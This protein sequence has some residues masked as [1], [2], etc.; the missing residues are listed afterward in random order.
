MRKFFILICLATF[1]SSTLNAQTNGA[2]PASNGSTTNKE[3]LK[4]EAPK[5]G[6]EIPPEK[7]VPINVPKIGVAINIDGKPDE[8]VWKTA[9]VFKDFYQTT[10]GNNV[11]PSKPTEAYMLYDEYNLYIAFRCWDDQGKVN[12]SVAK[13]D[14]VFNEDN[15][16]VWLDTYNDQRRAYILGFNPY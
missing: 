6:V 2:V 13:R 10:P 12:A 14:N 8:E 15:V 3:E 4:K 5:T 7:R 16:R 9:A 11:A 1:F